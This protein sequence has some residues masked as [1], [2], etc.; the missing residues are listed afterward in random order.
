MLGFQGQAGAAV[1]GSWEG[2]DM[3]MGVEPRTETQ[4]DLA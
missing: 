1:M 4:Q 3:G 2:G